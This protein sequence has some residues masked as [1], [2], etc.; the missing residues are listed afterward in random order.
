[1]IGRGLEA[2]WFMGMKILGG[3]AFAALAL[4]ACGGGGGGGATAAPGEAELER[5]RSDPA[6]VRLGEILAGADALLLTSARARYSLEGGGETL[7][8]DLVDTFECTGARCEA[9]DGTAVTIGSLTGSAAVLGVS[10]SAAALAR[11]G[12]FDAATTRGRLDITDESV[13]G[14]RV[15]AAPEVESYGF[16]GAHGYA[17]LEVGS[18]PLTGEVGEGTLAGEFAFARAYAAGGVSGSNPSGTGSAT[19]S[20]IVEASPAGAF[21]R[22]QGT[23]TVTVADLSRPRVGVSVSVPGHSVGAPG[24]ADMPLSTGRFSTGTVGSDYLAGAFHGPGHE[25]A[26][27]VFDTTRYLGAFGAKRAP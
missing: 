11:R 26:W 2:R 6:V 24:W 21:E 7:A 17:A 18:G 8:E 4:A 1:M 16:W 27:G 20:G 19:W 10:L 5:V 25:E 13:E 12:G 3:L 14:V 15:T 22:L 9:A 23:V